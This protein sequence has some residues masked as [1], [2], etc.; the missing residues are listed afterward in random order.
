M[1]THG[2]K[3]L[4]LLG[5]IIVGSALAA[6]LIAVICF[7]N[8]SPA[9]PPELLGKLVHYLRAKQHGGQDL[10]TGLLQDIS[11]WCNT[12]QALAQEPNA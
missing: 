6:I 5:A 1:R 4:G 10:T 8:R 11:A 9:P 12:G 2:V 7:A 3:R